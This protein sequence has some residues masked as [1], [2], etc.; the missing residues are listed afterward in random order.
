MGMDVC[1]WKGR[2]IVGEGGLSMG[3]RVSMG[4][5]VCPGGGR[6]VHGEGCLHG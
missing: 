6:C 3:E 4:R 2:C 1:P 5:E